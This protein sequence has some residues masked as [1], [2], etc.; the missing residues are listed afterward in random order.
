MVQTAVHPQAVYIPSLREAG[1]LWGGLVRQ[2]G[3]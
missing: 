3:S 1:A 2:L